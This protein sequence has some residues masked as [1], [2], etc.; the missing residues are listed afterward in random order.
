MFKRQP[1]RKLWI[2]NIFSLQVPSADE[3]PSESIFVNIIATITEIFIHPEKE[4][5]SLTLDDGSATIRARMFNEDAKTAKT[6]SVG[7]VIL[8]VARV[9]KYQQEIYLVPDF[10]KKIDPQWLKVRKE[11]LK[12]VAVTTENNTE[13]SYPEKNFTEE[14]TIEKDSS[15]QFFGDAPVMNEISSNSQSKKAQILTMLRSTPEGFDL[16]QLRQTANLSDAEAE[17]VI[18]TLLEEG[19]IYMPQPGRLKAI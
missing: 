9:K 7:D 15:S 10:V 6:L 18:T 1:A 4:F 3:Q 5:I 19:E 13:R 2:S 17:A 14:K 12:N 11:E 16:L 8:T